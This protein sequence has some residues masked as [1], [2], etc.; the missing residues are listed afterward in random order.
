MNGGASC[1]FY[2]TGNVVPGNCGIRYGQLPDA[3]KRCW[4]IA[5]PEPELLGTIKFFAE[6]CC[7]YCCDDCDC[8]CDCDCDDDDLFC[9]EDD[10]ADDVEVEVEDAPAADEATENA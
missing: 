2:H 4:S 9:D 7:K 5:C 1:L 10:D 3:Y 6:R 8:D